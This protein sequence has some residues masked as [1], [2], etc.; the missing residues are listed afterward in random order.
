MD[1]A[2]A[3]AIEMMMCQDTVFD[4]Y[5]PLE[6]IH[7]KSPLQGWTVYPEKWTDSVSCILNSKGDLVVN[8]IKQGKIFHY[9]EKDF[10]T[11]KLL[12]RLEGLANGKA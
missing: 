10:I 6:F 4:Q 11:P 12:E 3:I 5:C 7:M 9:V 2:S 8:N 1:L